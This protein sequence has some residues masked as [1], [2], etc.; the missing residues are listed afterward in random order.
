MAHQGLLSHNGSGMRRE[1]IR[2]RLLGGFALSVGPRTVDDGRWRLKKAM[3]LVKLLALAPRHRLHR[4]RVADVLWPGVGAKQASNSL[5]R[6]LHSARGVL[7]STAAGV[8]SNFL[9]LRGDLL[10]LCPDSPIWVDVD[11]FE[12]AAAEATGSLE[13]A[14]FRAAISLYAG[15]LL[16]ENLYED[17]AEERREDLRRSYGAL[18]V[19]LGALYENRGEYEK[20]IQTLK[21]AV[22]RHPAPDEEAHARLMRLYALSGRRLEAL[23]LY[24]RLRHKLSRELGVHPADATRRLYDGIRAGSVPVASPPTPGTKALAPNNLPVPLTSFV[25]RGKEVQGIERSL[26]MTRLMTLTGTGG[27]GKTRLALEVARGLVG[28]YAEGVWL[29]ELAPLSDPGLVARAVAT[30]LGVREHPDLTLTQAICNHLGSGR[31]LLVLDNCEHLVGAAARFARDLLSTCEGLTVLATSREPLR[32]SGEIVWPVPTLSLPD[33]APSYTVEDLLASEAVRLFVERARSRLPD[34]DLTDENAGAVASVCRELDGIPL[35]IELSTA[36]M[37]A[38]AVEQIVER[39]EGSL[40]LLSGGDRTL[41]QRHQTLRATL[42]WSYDLLSEPER[43]LFRRLSVFAG[44]WPLEAAEGVGS[45][46]GIEAGDVL[47]LLSRLVDK[48]MVIVEQT[49]GRA[50]RYGMLEP[51]RRYGQE[52]LEASGEAQT[53]RRAHARWY[54]RLAEEVEPWLRGAHQEVW[55]ERLER[56]YGNLRAALG[57]ALDNEEVDL[58]LWFGGALGEFWY[59]GGNLGEGRRWLE[60][61]LSKSSGTPPTPAR[62]RAL[63]RAGW[64]AWEQGDYMDSVA[65]SKE[66][67]A[68]S[69]RFGDSAGCVAALSNLGWA[70]LLADDLQRA[71]TLADEALALARTIR[72]TGGIARA[73]LIPGL[74]AVAAGANEEALKLHEESLSLARK[75]EDSIATHISL[76]MG[77]FARLGLGDGPRAQA[78]CAKSLALPTQPRVA[79]ATA[80]QL[81]ASAALAGS[82]GLPLRSASL[83]GAAESLRETIGATLSPVELRV[84]GPYIEAAREKLDISVWNEAWAEGRAMTLELAIEYA[85]S[86]E[87]LIRPRPTRASGEVP[88]GGQS[89]NVLTGRQQEVAFLV[90]SGLTNRQIASE[91]GISENTV[92]NHVARILKKLDATS[93]SRIAIWVAESEQTRD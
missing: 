67:L 25:G 78:L 50:L 14:A 70:A 47:D 18:L 28:N 46:D 13:P 37:G 84:Y 1:T 23:R 42:D 41:A 5:H 43:V 39:L 71:S 66:S 93:R 54:Y 24:E 3:S 45:G 33:P 16:P 35:A 76:V 72:D 31:T 11:A 17:W 90:A 48:S 10:Q 2:I 64:I 80:F 83:W 62:S 79:N 44:G 40:K 56:E 20:G 27:S 36:R 59:M 30:T 74:A 12:N 53:I 7:E 60:A 38:L 32:V 63:V 34:F 89:D 52:F 21:G 55:L 87:R 92:A 61:A 8:G 81:H 91:L 29:A 68:L 19:E 88:A 86:E 51:V 85:A 22:E 26:S 9:V 77:T 4:E 75:A 49:D 65:L 6:T 15:D 82:Q 73:L 69:R 57:W 58:G